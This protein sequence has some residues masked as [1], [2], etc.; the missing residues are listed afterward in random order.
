[1]IMELP[2]SCCEVAFPDFIS[3]RGFQRRGPEVP[4]AAAGELE[5]CL[6]RQLGKSDGQARQPD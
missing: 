2:I 3:Q 1:M 5:A 6:V 4:E